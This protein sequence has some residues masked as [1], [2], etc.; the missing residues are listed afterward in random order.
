MGTEMS[1]NWEQ[2]G[3]AEGSGNRLESCL[4][5]K[6]RMAGERQGRLGCQGKER[7]GF[8]CASPPEFGSF[9]AWAGGGQRHG[10][11]GVMGA[12]SSRGRDGFWL[13]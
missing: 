9:A 7:R 5:E 8:L 1:G 2:A 4:R 12:A 10:S 13:H 11:E 6:G 3:W